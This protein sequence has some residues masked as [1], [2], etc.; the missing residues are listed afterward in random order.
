LAQRGKTILLCSH[1]LADVEDVCDRISI[2]YGGRVQAEGRVRELLEQAD[3][4]QITTGPMSEAAMDEIKAIVAREKVE[5]SISSP[6]ERLETFFVRTVAAAR[7]QAQPTSGAVSTTEIGG[8]LAAKE[9]DLLEGLVRGGTEEGQGEDAALGPKAEP[10]PATPSDTG[11]L[12]KLTDGTDSVTTV[13]PD[14][15]LR[16][17]LETAEQDA[18]ALESTQR[19]VLDRLIDSNKPSEGVTEVTDPD[20]KRGEAGDA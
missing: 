11:V 10:A 18:A 14:A 20:R 1:L 6:M 16:E 9:S 12:D 2:L 7:R 15:D 3:K 5:C 8:F 19:D 13:R 4:R 17:T